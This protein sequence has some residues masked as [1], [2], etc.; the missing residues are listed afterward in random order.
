M[1]SFGYFPGVWLLYADVSEHSISSIF[2][3]W[4]WSILHI[5]PMKMEQIE[6]SETSAYIIQ[7]PGKYPKEYIHDFSF[8]V[9]VCLSVCPSTL[10]T[11]KS[12]GTDFH[13]IYLRNFR[14]KKYVRKIPVQLQSDTYNGYF[15]WRPNLCAFMVTSGWVR[16]MMMNVPDKI[17]RERRQAVYCTCNVTLGRVRSTVLVVEK[18]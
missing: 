7:T 9:S 10:S 16:L 5:Q 2:I 3:G 15:T 1:Y 6:C 18:Q 11:A 12:Q 17:C 8:V 14:E 13:E 4:L